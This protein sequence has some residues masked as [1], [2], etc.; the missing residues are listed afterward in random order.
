[1]VIL[2]NKY[3][4]VEISGFG[5]NGGTYEKYNKKGNRSIISGGVVGGGT[6]NVGTDRTGGYTV[7]EKT[8]CKVEFEEK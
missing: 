8:K 3:D 7:Y 2:A 1:M 6:A 5:G 4:I